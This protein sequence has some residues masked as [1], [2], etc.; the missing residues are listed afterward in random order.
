MVI[1]M[2]NVQTNV[3]SYDEA[4]KQAL[5]GTDG[6][7]PHLQG[8]NVWRLGDNKLFIGKAIELHLGKVENLG[9]IAYVTLTDKSK[10]VQDALDIYM[11]G[12]PGTCPDNCEFFKECN[13]ESEE[14]CTSPGSPDLVAD[15][16][17]LVHAYVVIPVEDLEELDAGMETIEAVDRIMKYS[18]ICPNLMDVCSL[19]SAIDQATDCYL[20]QVKL[21][22]DSIKRYITERSLTVTNDPT[23]YVVEYECLEGEVAEYDRLGILTTD[24]FDVDSY[25]EVELLDSD[26]LIEVDI[27][28]YS[29]KAKRYID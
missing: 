26:R 24:G 27:D 18:M 10:Q 21:E 20:Y 17:G 5:A 7:C 16:N 28:T 13:S 8:V 2:K 23:S 11:D 4:V 1:K 14:S 19:V 29:P 3:I 6:N 22:A 12:E 25:F 9:P 15:V